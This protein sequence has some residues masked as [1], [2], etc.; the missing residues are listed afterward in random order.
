MKNYIGLSEG[1]T[2]SSECIEYKGSPVKP[3][4]YCLANVCFRL[5]NNLQTIDFIGILS[6]KMTTPLIYNLF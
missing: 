2:K 5:I 6:I 4:K 1:L 3:G